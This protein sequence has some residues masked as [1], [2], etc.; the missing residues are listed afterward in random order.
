M[1]L[2]QLQYYI[3][4]SFKI[5]LCQDNPFDKDEN[6][7]NNNIFTISKPN[8]LNIKKPI[9]NNDK[10]N[11]KDRKVNLLSNL[12]KFNHDPYEQ[13]RVMAMLQFIK[14]MT[15]NENLSNL[16]EEIE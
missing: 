4:I 11:I 10:I 13:T 9:N 6:I 5:I 14:I 12:N 7:K 3:I 1:N 2:K 16:V 15:N 8:Q